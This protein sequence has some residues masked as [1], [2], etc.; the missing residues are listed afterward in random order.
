MLPW[1]KSVHGPSPT[2]DDAPNANQIQEDE[3][4]EQENLAVSDRYAT[5]INQRTSP[6]KF[7]GNLESAASALLPWFKRTFS[8]RRVRDGSQ[9]NEGAY[10]NNASQNNQQENAPIHELQQEEPEK[11]FQHEH[12]NDQPQ[13]TAPS[14]QLFFGEWSE[15]DKGIFSSGSAHRVPGQAEPARPLYPLQNFR[16]TVPSA[17]W[18]TQDFAQPRQ[19]QD[20][21]MRNNMG[22]EMPPTTQSQGYD[23]SNQK[24]LPT[25]W[26]V[27]PSNQAYGTSNRSPPPQ[28]QGYGMSSY[29]QPPPEWEVPQDVL[30]YGTSNQPPP[31][32]GYGMAQGG[33]VYRELYPPPPD[34]GMS[35]NNHGHGSS[36]FGPGYG[37]ND[38]NQ[39][40]IYGSQNLQGNMHDPPLPKKKSHHATIV[41]Q[42][43][44]CPICSHQI[45]ARTLT[46]HV[47]TTHMAPGQN[48][49]CT[50]C[51]KNYSSGKFIILM[52][53]QALPGKS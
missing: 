7:Y 9:I 11:Q 32:L 13:A 40:Y 1:N 26:G 51:K 48:P 15:L 18:D 5:P 12:A 49:H 3:S 16:S 20:T 53:R 22:Y 19:N 34:Y 24:G 6:L 46:E 25:E 2:D 27:P 35:Q 14:S 17:G 50:I 29:P 23:V 31:P 43:A 52:K 38:L 45:P 4:N 47:E 8:P 39:G 10:S 41:R 28:D 33:Q 42:P 37:Q 44:T 21:E 36:T 30:A